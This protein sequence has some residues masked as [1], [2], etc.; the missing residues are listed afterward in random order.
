ML[1]IQAALDLVR[2]HLGTSPRARHSIFVG[3]AMH[4]LAEPLMADGTLWEITGLC[5][6]LDFEATRQNPSQHGILAAQWL[7]GQLPEAALVAIRAH[8]HRTGITSDTPI[9]H[10]LKLADT[11]AVISAALGERTT[12]V[13]DSPDVEALLADEFA[14]R[15]HLPTMLL[16]H[17]HRLGITLPALARIW[18][19]GPPPW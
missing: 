15:P 16:A 7:E 14:T 3:F 9:T 4:H 10:A 18:T 1:S 19:L 11:L 12:A 5:H 6:D 17:S 13:L 2:D 8:D